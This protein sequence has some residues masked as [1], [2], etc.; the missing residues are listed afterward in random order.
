MSIVYDPERKRAT[1]VESGL[2]IEFDRK[3]P[4]PMEFDE[5]YKLIYN[6]QVFPFKVYHNSGEYKI[7]K[8]NP[9]IKGSEYSRAIRKLNEI[10]FILDKIDSSIREK[11]KDPEFRKI[12]LEVWLRLVSELYYWARCSVDVSIASPGVSKADDS[13]YLEEKAPLRPLDEGGNS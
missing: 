1:H 3:G 13:W 9:D 5:Y 12:F 10:N 4:Y 8:K 7:T 6:D 2:A 11:L